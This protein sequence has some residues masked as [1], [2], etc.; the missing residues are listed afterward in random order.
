ML[1]E[2][3]LT[4]QILIILSYGNKNSEDSSI[5]E[6]VHNLI[7]EI[8]PMPPAEDGAFAKSANCNKML[9]HIGGDDDS[10][11]NI[12]RRMLFMLEGEWLFN[13][14]GFH[15]FRREMLGRYIQ[16]DMAD[17]QLAL[18][19]LDDIIRYYRT[20][21]VD[22]E[23]K[24][25]ESVGKPWAIRNIK[26]VFSRKLLYASGLFSIAKTV[27]RTRKEKIDLLE[28]LFCLPVIDRMLDICGM[29]QMRTI[30]DS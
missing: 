30:L 23:Y 25:S 8:V 13:E 16:E 17:H 6:Q 2:K 20:V 14:K 28:R 7:A 15:N 22:Y 21:A 5:V 4:N 11:Y 1:G 27:D 29:D 26:L 12:T 19:L 18:F 3:P 10:N 9:E 24:I